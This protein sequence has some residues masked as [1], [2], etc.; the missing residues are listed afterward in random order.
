[1]CRYVLMLYVGAGDPKCKSSNCTGNTSSSTPPP[2]WCFEQQIWLRYGSPSSTCHP[3]PWHLPAAGHSLYVHTGAFILARVWVTW[4][5][6]V[7]WPVVVLHGTSIFHWALWSAGLSLVQP[8]W[9]GFLHHG[10][11]GVSQGKRLLA[12]QKE[13][14]GYHA[15][16]GNG[17]FSLPQV[18][19]VFR[20]QTMAV[21][22]FKISDWLWWVSASGSSLG[23]FFLS[24]L[25]NV[26]LYH[27]TKKSGFVSGYQLSYCKRILSHSSLLDLQKGSIC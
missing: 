11:S 5:S 21:R 2:L 9:Q 22:E 17:D 7:L 24:Y 3:W 18:G 8:S 14:S 27:I 1:M 25:T 23:L 19:K 16:A 13:S 26:F 10:Y 12:L 20:I 4:V 15:S 6:E